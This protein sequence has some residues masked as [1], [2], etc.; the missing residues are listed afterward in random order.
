MGTAIA[1]F[2]AVPRANVV[3]QPLSEEHLRTGQHGD[4]R[5]EAT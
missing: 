1:K 3:A 5:A 2:L 4:M